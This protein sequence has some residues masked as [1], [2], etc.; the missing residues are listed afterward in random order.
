MKGL[1][2]RKWLGVSG[3][4]SIMAQLTRVG[5]LE[6]MKL[7]HSTTIIEKRS[8]EVCPILKSIERLV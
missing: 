1:L 7:S 6:L 4:L 8:L 5:D 3:N 2:F